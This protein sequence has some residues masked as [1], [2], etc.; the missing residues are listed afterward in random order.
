MMVSRPSSLYLGLASTLWGTPAPIAFSL[1][2]ACGLQFVVG[3]GHI[4]LA[5][6]KCAAPDRFPPHRLS[7]PSPSRP[8]TSH[9]PYSNPSLA[10]CS[11]LSRIDRSKGRREEE[12]SSYPLAPFRLFIRTRRSPGPRRSGFRFLRAIRLE[13]PRL[14]TLLVP[15]LP[16]NPPFP[17][18]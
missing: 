18:R 15:A 13:R 16:M 4:G 10:H 11:L 9:T 8:L 6:C 3:F 17:A 7:C 2:S 5:F 14:P 12:A 1:R